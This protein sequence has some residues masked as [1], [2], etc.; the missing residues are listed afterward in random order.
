MNKPFAVEYTVSGKRR[1]FETQSEAFAF[2]DASKSECWV[3]K[4]CEASGEY[5]TVL[6]IPGNEG[7]VTEG[8]KLVTVI[9]HEVNVD[10]DFENFKLTEEQVKDLVIYGAAYTQDGKRVPP[11]SVTM[12][13]GPAPDKSVVVTGMRL[14]G[15]K[16]TTLQGLIGRTV[17]I[18]L[19]TVNSNGCL[20]K[21]QAEHIARKLHLNSEF[22]NGLLRRDL[23]FNI[24]HNFGKFG[25]TSRSLL[26]QMRG[27]YDLLFSDSDPEHFMKMYRSMRH[28]RAARKA[29]LA[30]DGAICTELAQYLGKKRKPAALNK[31]R[32]LK[33]IRRFLKG[34]K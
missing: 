22:G 8:K 17:M 28:S 23:G 26:D 34:S 20:T 6:V 3:M 4:F 5:I 14:E 32:K 21:L 31:V 2:K 15:E 18:D 11:Q 19:K 30:Y 24:N 25:G 10:P 13:F 7:R 1:Y 33:R 9:N 12:D 29:Q 16:A 27:D